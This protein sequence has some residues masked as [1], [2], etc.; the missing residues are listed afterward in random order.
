M[1]KQPNHARRQESVTGGAE[2]DFGGA[3]AVYFV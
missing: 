3:R 1:L 2:I